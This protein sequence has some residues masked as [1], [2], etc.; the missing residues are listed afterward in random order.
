M[1]WKYANVARSG[2]TTEP[3]VS[4]DLVR[5]LSPIL[6][7]CLGDRARRIQ[8]RMEEK[9][10]LRR[11][12]ATVSSLKA[13]DFDWD[14]DCD[15]EA[16]FTASSPAITPSSPWIIVLSVTGQRDGQPD[17]SHSMTASA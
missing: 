4:D 1:E 2:R 8:R 12:K 9:N 16:H 14:W 5:A 10:N 3:P 17:R 15:C 13:T 11:P 7:I 6:W